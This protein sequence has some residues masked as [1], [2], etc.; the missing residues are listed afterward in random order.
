MSGETS[1][2]ARVALSANYKLLYVSPE[3]VIEG[4]IQIS[5]TT[6]ELSASRKINGILESRYGICVGL[7]CVSADMQFRKALRLL[8]IWVISFD[9]IVTSSAVKCDGI[10]NFSDPARSTKV[11]VV[12]LLFVS[13]TS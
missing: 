3:H 9:H 2:T 10:L 8:L 4:E 13:K 1:T 7:R 11:S 6:L 5:R 12:N